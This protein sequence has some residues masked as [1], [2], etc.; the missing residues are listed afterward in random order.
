[1]V[2]HDI[3]KTVSWHILHEHLIL[4]YCIY[5]VFYGFV[6]LVLKDIRFFQ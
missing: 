1:M 4:I 5:Y 6:S 2:K 3:Y